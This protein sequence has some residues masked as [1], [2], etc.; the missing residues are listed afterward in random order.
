MLLR[1]S[2]RGVTN[3]LDYLTRRAHPV[4]FSG[5]WLDMERMITL[6]H[7]LSTN[8]LPPFAA[9]RCVEEDGA[10]PGRDF[11]D[12]F[13]S[14]TIFDT[15][16]AIARVVRGMAYTRRMVL[17][18]SQSRDPQG[19][20]LTWHWSVLQ[21]DS[22][23][24]R[25]APRREDRSSVAIEVDY[26]GGSFP[27]AEAGEMRSSRVEIALCV[28]N[29]VHFSPP[30]L[31]SLYYLNNETRQYAGDGRI[32]SVDYASA[33]N[34]Y[35]DPM[36]SLPRRWRDLYL[37]DSHNRLAGW[38][39][40]RGQEMESFTADGARVLTRDARGR[41]LTARTVVY[42]P[43]AAAGA[44]GRNKLPEVVQMDGDKIR[45]YRYA[46]DDDIVGELVSEEPY[47]P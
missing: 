43:Q 19:R 25:I 41:P 42:R 9:V 8:A 7:D 27:V 10:V 44:A 39:R 18:S 12:A 47:R 46:G 1:H 4:A 24:I 32:L 28:D 36:L 2:Q 40:F 5:K 31:I 35:T 45:T 37:Y 14:E 11:C 16:A 29:G 23:K 33:T 38:S 6:A 17:D 13:A 34:R 3:R 20:P 15:P 30:A 26:H 21:G 22:A